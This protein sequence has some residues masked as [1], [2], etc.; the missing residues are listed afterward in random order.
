MPCSRLSLGALKRAFGLLL[1]CLLLNQ[2]RLPDGLSCIPSFITADVS[3]LA[4]VV[5][6]RCHG[7]LP[8][9]SKRVQL[10]VPPVNRVPAT[11]AVTYLT[12]YGSRSRRRSASSPT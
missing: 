3:D 9:R 4:V 8:C 1:A 5:P 7:R 2:L 6:V 12:P 10:Y 11:R